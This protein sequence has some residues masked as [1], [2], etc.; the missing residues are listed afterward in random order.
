MLHPLLN[1]NGTILLELKTSYSLLFSHYLV[2]LNGNKTCHYANSAFFFFFPNIIS[3]ILYRFKKTQRCVCICIIFPSLFL[4]FLLTKKIF[5]TVGFLFIISFCFVFYLK[6]YSQLGSLLI[7]EDFPYFWASQVALVVKNP[8]TNTGDIRDAS[9]APGQ[10]D[11][12]MEGM[13]THSSILVWRIPWT[14]EPGGLKSIELQRVGH[15]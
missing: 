7:H 15:Y 8:L 1:A 5:C 13:A 4:K 10:E 11:P 6:T 9:S 14:E 2:L 3:N 12:L